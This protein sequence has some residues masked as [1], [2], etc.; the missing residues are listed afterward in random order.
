MSLVRTVHDLP[1][2][3]HTEKLIIE[4]IWASL[5]V[6]H[7]GLRAQLAGRLYE[8]QRLSWAC[9]G[10]AKAHWVATF[11]QLPSGA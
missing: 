1:S 6:L 11:P 4:A 3:I 9:P 8:V 10:T 2:E 5:H 7:A